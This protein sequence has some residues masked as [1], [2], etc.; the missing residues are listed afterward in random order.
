MILGQSSLSQINP[1]GQ[2]FFDC[3]GSIFS[4]MVDNNCLAITGV[5]DS[6]PTDAL[7]IVS[8]TVSGNTGNVYSDTSS[9]ANSWFVRQDKGF[10]ENFLW[11]PK[12]ILIAAGLPTIYSTVICLIWYF[13]I[14][15][16]ITAFILGR[17]A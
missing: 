13:I 7:P 14:G 6:T 17:F 10:L 4:N 9:I 8:P 5:K 12:N 15:L 11:A 16:L 1:T 3:K 2:R